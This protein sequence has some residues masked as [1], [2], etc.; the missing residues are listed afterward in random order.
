VKALALDQ[1]SACWN[2]AHV[3]NSG[4]EVGFFGATLE[5]VKGES[6]QPKRNHYYD[7][8]EILALLVR[9]AL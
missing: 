4:F 9:Q 3:S 7:L 1:N 6:N 8:C 2:S 5:Q